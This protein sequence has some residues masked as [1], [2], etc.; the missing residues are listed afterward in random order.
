MKRGYRYGSLARKWFCFIGLWFREC[1]REG[2]GLS[3]S[4]TSSSGARGFYRVELG[5]V[6]VTALSDGTTPLYDAP[7]GAGFHGDVIAHEDRYGKSAS[8]PDRGD[9]FR[10]ELPGSY[11][12]DQIV[13]TSIIRG[14]PANIYYGT[15]RCHLETDFRDA[16]SRTPR[17]SMNR[18]ETGRR[19]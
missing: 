10:V 6:E 11:T 19:C 8:P 2:A 9:Q 14:T 15:V 5:D 16:L 12:A 7:C 13:D 17:R 3:E 18:P 4:L 1:S